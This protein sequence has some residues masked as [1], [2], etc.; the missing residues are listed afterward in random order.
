MMLFAFIVCSFILFLF[1]AMPVFFRAFA[2]KKKKEQH[3]KDG[4]DDA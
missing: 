2:K 4:E 1:L 3:D